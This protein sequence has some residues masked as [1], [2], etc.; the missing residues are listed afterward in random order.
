[1]VNINN[2]M[3]NLISTLI[4]IILVILILF[5]TN[6][7]LILKSQ[8]PHNEE[9]IMKEETIYN[10]EVYIAKIDLNVEVKQVEYANLNELMNNGADTDYMYECERKFICKNFNEQFNKLMYGD[11]I[12]YRHENQIDKYQIVSN[13]IINKQEIQ[14]INI[15]ENELKLITNINDLPEKFRCVNARKIIDIYRIQGYNKYI[16]YWGELI[17]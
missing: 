17:C 12:E 10:T 11:I 1:M 2:K 3:I 7:N 8:N 6:H 5:F 14:K 13:I 9:N 15:Y 16:N 4:S